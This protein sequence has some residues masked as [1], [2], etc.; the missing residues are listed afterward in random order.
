MT[1]KS[2]PKIVPSSGIGGHR[3]AVSRQEWRCRG[4][5]EELMGDVS[6]ADQ[7]VVLGDEDCGLNEEWRFQVVSLV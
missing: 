2:Q 6:T 7:G 3:E 5:D 4:E 1:S